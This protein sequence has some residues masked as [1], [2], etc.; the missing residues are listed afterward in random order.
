MGIHFGFMPSVLL[1]IAFVLVMVAVIFVPAWI[2][3][4]RWR[5]TNTRYQ[6]WKTNHCITCN[7]DL[8]AHKPGD[9]CPE[10]GTPVPE[11]HGIMLG[12][13]DRP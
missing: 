9:K 6:R 1:S 11:P 13:G 8:R 2:F 4:Q 12:K 3:V 10:C 7:Y 5:K